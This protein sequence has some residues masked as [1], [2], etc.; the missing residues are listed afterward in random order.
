[1]RRARDERGVVFPSPVV[2]LS[3]IAVAMAAVAFVATR[4]AEPTEREVTTVARSQTPSP[5]PSASACTSLIAGLS[6][7]SRQKR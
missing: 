6:G 5:S 4:G 2:M 7:T 3:I 1:M